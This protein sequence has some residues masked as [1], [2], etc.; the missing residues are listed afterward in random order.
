MVRM[1]DQRNIS[2]LTRHVDEYIAETIRRSTPA[3]NA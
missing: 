2:A 3:P 1:D